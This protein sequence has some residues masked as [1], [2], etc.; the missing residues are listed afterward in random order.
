M[1]DT[2]HRLAVRQAAGKRVDGG[3]GRPVTVQERA[4]D[5]VDRLGLLGGEDMGGV[6]HHLATGP[7]K[8]PGQGLADSR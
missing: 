8:G 7:R 4:E 2:Q 5:G 1:L 3:A 6:L